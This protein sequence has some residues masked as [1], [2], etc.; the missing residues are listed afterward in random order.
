MAKSFTYIDLHRHLDLY[1]NM[2]GAI[3]TSESGK[4]LTV[5]VTTTPRAWPRNYDLIRDKQYVRA[6]LGLHPQLVNANSDAELELF[7]TYFHQTRYIG[8]VGMDAGKEYVHTVQD[9]E[10]IFREILKACAE[11]GGK[12]L[13]VHSTRSATKVLNAIEE[14]LPRSRGRVILHWFTGTVDEAG[15][16]I[17]LGCYFSV[18]SR[19]LESKRGRLLI[20]SLPTDRVLTETDGPFG[21]GGDALASENELRSLYTS[22]M[23][24][25]SVSHDGLLKQLS[26]N[27]KAALG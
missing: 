13:S 7:M 22:L 12:V 21:S 1:D 15:H 20:M 26:M 24:M 23:D 4:I 10:R 27:L 18:N 6:S 3:D 11:S 25:W 8:E 2:Q 14:L 17:R 5:G 9:Q 19:M 16:A